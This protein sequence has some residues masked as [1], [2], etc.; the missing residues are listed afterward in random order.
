MHFTRFGTSIPH[1][2]LGG[3]FF[4]GGLGTQRLRTY[5]C[6]AIEGVLCKEAIRE[7]R[8]TYEEVA[9]DMKATWLS[10]GWLLGL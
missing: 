1:I 8:L 7:V 2:E 10:T 3:H 5:G 6:V 4:W 9:V